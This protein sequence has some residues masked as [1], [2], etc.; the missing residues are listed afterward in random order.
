[1]EV[2]NM[3]N[4]KNW[5]LYNGD[6]CEVMR[7]IPDESIHYSVFSPP[8]SS[9]YTYSNSDRDL[10]NSKNDDEFFEHF[11]FIVKELFRIIKPGRNVSI[12]CMNMPTSKERDGFIGLKDF[13]GDIIREF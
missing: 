4:G 3:K 10:G 2:L 13:R 7:S 12:H 1:M 6:S 5:T 11:D 8:F 9:L